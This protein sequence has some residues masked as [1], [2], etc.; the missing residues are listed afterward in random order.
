MEILREQA[1]PERPSAWILAAVAHK[2]AQSQ[3]VT[4]VS[5]TWIQQK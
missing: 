4:F 3:E 1:A 5:K 2:H